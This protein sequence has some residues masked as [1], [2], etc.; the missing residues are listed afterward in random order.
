MKLKPVLLQSALV[1]T[2]CASAGL[3]L[4]N[5]L[6]QAL[7][8]QPAANQAPEVQQLPAALE[9]ILENWER[10]SAKIQKLEG[11]HI[12][13]EYDDV[14]QVEKQSEGKFYYEHPDKGRIDIAGKKIPEGAKS[15]KPNNKGGFYALKPGNDER[16]I[17]DGKRIFSIDENEKKYEV[18]PI[19][20]ERRG[21]NIMEGPLPFLFGMPANV[22]KQR[23]FLKLLVNTPDQII[24]A[25][26]PRRR[27]DSQNYREAKIKLDP[28]TYLPAAVQLI[29]PS[30]NQSTVYIFEN[31]VA[32]KSRGIL[33]GIFGKDPFTP[34]LDDYR[35]EGKVVAVAGEENVKRP[36]QQAAAP[37]QQATFKVP[38][39]VGRDY[40]TAQKLLKQMGLESKIYPGDPAQEP[41]Q[42]IY[43]VYLQKPVPGEVIQQGGIIHLKLYTDPSKPKN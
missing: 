23:Y 11:N 40:Q 30:G 18:Y 28:K 17:C 36:V 12:R 43:H 19:P 20:L 9:Q 3:L 37:V 39:M 10:E 15:D 32:N 21:T 38:N 25:A 34:D 31:V 24:I 4:C 26:K 35:L 33:G 14:F 1:V 6:S 16:W 8:Q 41:G 29:H 42:Q 13:R 22:A 2:C 27:L 7:G 5:Q